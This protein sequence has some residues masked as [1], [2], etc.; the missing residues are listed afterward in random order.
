[1]SQSSVE[2]VIGALM[3]DEA[4][5]HRFAQDPR[6][7]IQRLAESGFELTHCE[8]HVLASLDPQNLERC[9]ELIDARLQKS[10]LKGGLR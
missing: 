1:M 7:E 8:R 10:D 3:T 2:R 6:S 5:R 4:L 9:A